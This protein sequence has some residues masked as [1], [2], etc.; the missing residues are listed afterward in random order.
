METSLSTRSFIARPTH[1]LH[2]SGIQVRLDGVPSHHLPLLLTAYQHKFGRDLEAMSCHLVDNVAI[3]WDQLGTDLLDDAPPALI[4]AL[5]GGEQWPSRTLNLITPNGAPPV[6]MTV[7]EYTADAQDMQW[8]YILHREGIEVVSLLHEDL[9][10]L[11][12]WSTDPR[13]VFSDDPE[14]WSSL[15]PAPVIQAVRSAAPQNA[16]VAVP[17]T[18]SPQRTAAHR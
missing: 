12:D 13:T 15:E 4:A 5:T 9:G 18:A 14:H 17:A 6:R 7:T 10:P 3:G 2:Y 16:P 1:P 8:G 11:V